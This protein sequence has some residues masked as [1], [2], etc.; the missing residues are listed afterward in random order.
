[1]KQMPGRIFAAVL[2]LIMVFAAPGTV[3]PDSGEIV[4]DD[5]VGGMTGTVVDD[6]VSGQTTQDDAYAENNDGD[7]TYISNDG[8][9]F[10]IPRVSDKEARIF[11]YAGLFT[12]DE[13]AS[14]AESIR[15]VE[16]SKNADIVI[17]TSDDV[18][19][20]AYY[21]TDTSMR[22]A[23]QFLVDNGFKEDSF[24][25]IIDMNNRVF[26]TAGYGTYGTEKYTGWGQKV[27]D[28][29]K[30]DLSEKRYAP[31]AKTYIGQV[32]R[33]DNPLLA[34]IPTPF[35]ILISGVMTVLGLLGFNMH[36]SLTQPSKANTPPVKVVT[37]KSRK[38]DE[39]YLGT[40]VH[41]RHIPRSN[42]GGG[43]SGGGGGGFSGGGFSSGS[44]GSHSGGGGHF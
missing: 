9:V 34:A 22:Y 33:L 35:S 19:R 5:Y 24:I 44:G 7:D 30:D 18:P 3:F 41:R 6:T 29:V 17:L 16:D 14:L 31:A 21:S 12:A 38:H 23:R 39:H 32:D 2:F 1:M 20:D 37:Y 10:Q 40:T 42:G 11:D 13:T 36:H 8:T 4:F 27:Y 26:W 25:C 28:L 15:K 43:F